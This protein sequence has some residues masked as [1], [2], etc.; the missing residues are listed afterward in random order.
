MCCNGMSTYRATFR[1]D[2]IVSINSSVQCAGCVYKRR[3]QKSPGIASSSRI[4]VHNVVASAGNACVAAWKRSGEAIA[5]LCPSR[6]S[7][8]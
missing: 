1:L 5:R 6:R 8:P 2:A 7:S 4:N 3:I